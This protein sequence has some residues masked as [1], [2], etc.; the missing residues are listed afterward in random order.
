M[1]AKPV[2]H[3]AVLLKLDGVRKTFGEDGPRPTRV[4]AGVELELRSGETVGVLGPSGSGKSTLLYIAGTLEAPSAGRVLFRGEDLAQLGPR[5]LARFR[6]EQVGF[7][8]Q[9]HHLL[10]QLSALENA[11]VPTLAGA[12]EDPGADVARAKDLMQRVGLGERL[13]HRPAE[14]SGGERQRVAVVRALIN[15][16]ALLLADEPTGALDGP[17]AEAL[18]DLLLE[19]NASE[20]VAL[21]CVTHSE[22][23]AARLGR[24]VRLADGVLSE[25]AQAASGG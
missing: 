25:D 21:L 7:V 22:A 13:T 24:V 20:G 4:L 11:L 5:E 9:H 1:N 6:N 3:D 15:R 10:P 12:R 8:F 16:P 19:C 17:S 14:L 2:T 23:L 18:G